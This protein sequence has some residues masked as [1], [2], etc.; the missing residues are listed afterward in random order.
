[1]PLQKN[2]AIASLVSMLG[3]EMLMVHL[4]IQ[5]FKPAFVY[6]KIQVIQVENWI[7]MIISETH[8]TKPFANVPN[9]DSAEYTATAFDIDI[10]S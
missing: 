5:G 7:Y 9:A 10:L 2:K 1:M 8:I 4:S 6:L 3:V